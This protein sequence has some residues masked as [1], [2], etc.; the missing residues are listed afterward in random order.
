MIHLN[1]LFINSMLRLVKKLASSF[2]TVQFTV[3][4]Q[5]TR[6]LNFYYVNQLDQP[7]RVRL[8]TDWTH[9]VTGLTSLILN[10]TN[11]RADIR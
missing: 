8:K 1:N 10:G 3:A 2:S 9:P 5:E 11:L 7:V 4:T 6:Y